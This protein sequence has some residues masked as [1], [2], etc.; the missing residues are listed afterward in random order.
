M[1]DAGLQELRQSDMQCLCDIM[2]DN[3]CL[4]AC[5]AC[6]ELQFGSNYDQDL[7]GLR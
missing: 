3:L 2:T 6:L 7:N 4:A 1:L 5:V